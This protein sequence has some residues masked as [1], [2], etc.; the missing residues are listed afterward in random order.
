MKQGG[1]SCNQSKKARPIPHNKKCSICGRLYGIEEI[2]DRHEKQC[3]QYNR[4][5]LYYDKETD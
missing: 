2:K 3:K 1:I 5:W 4:K